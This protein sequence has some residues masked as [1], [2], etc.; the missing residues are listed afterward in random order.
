MA[1][2]IGYSEEELSVTT[3]HRMGTLLTHNGAL[4]MYEC[5]C[6]HSYRAIIALYCITMLY[7]AFLCLSMHFYY[8][9]FE[10]TLSHIQSDPVDSN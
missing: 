7:N 4:P 5:V 1:Y 3:D 9:A 2:P 8:I 6:I 10:T